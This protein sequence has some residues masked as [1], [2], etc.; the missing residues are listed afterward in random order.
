MSARNQVARGSFTFE[1][2]PCSTG[3]PPAPHVAKTGLEFLIILPPSTSSGLGSGLRSPGTQDLMLSYTLSTFLSLTD[4]FL[5]ICQLSTRAL[6]N[7]AA[8]ACPKPLDVCS[9]HLFTLGQDQVQIQLPQCGSLPAIPQAGLWALLD[10]TEG[11]LL[12]AGCRCG[13]TAGEGLF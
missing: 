4:Y 10:D 12:K 6:A 5:S 9:P 1:A 2:V 8:H 13:Q 7:T 11:P 3:W